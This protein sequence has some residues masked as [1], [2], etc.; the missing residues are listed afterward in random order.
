MVDKQESQQRGRQ[1]GL[2][3]PRK[4]VQSVHTHGRAQVPQT[5][6]PTTRIPSTAFGAFMSPLRRLAPAPGPQPKPEPA[7]MP[8]VLPY[9]LPSMRIPP[10]RRMAPQRGTTG[11]PAR[12]EPLL[13]PPP[14]G[15]QRVRTSN[16]REQTFVTNQC[17][18]LPLYLGR[19]RTE[20]DKMLERYAPRPRDITFLPPLSTSSAASSLKFPEKKLLC[21]IPPPTH[22]KNDASVQQRGLD[23]SSS[24]STADASPNMLRSPTTPTF[25]PPL[26]LPYPSTAPVTPEENG[27]QIADIKNQPPVYQLLSNAPFSPEHSALAD[28]T[29]IVLPRLHP[30]KPQTGSIPEDPFKHSTQASKP[31]TL[32]PDTPLQQSGNLLSIV[33]LG[34]RHPQLPYPAHVASSGGRLSGHHVSSGRHKSRLPRTNSQVKAVS[35]AYHPKTLPPYRPKTPP[36]GWFLSQNQVNATCRSA[37]LPEIPV[38]G[39]KTFAE[40]SLEEK[41]FKPGPIK[42]D[43]ELLPVVIAPKAINMNSVKPYRP[44][45]MKNGLEPIANGL[46]PSQID[47][48]QQSMKKLASKP[49]V[50]QSKKLDPLALSLDLPQLPIRDSIAPAKFSDYTQVPNPQYTK[51]SRGRGP[52]ILME[53]ERPGPFGIDEAKIFALKLLVALLPVKKN[54][55]PTPREIQ[56]FVDACS[57]VGQWLLS[58][59]VNVSPQCT[60]ITYGIFLFRAAM[61]L[62]NNW[63]TVSELPR[64]L[65]DNWGMPCA[66]IEGQELSYEW[67]LKVQDIFFRSLIE[68]YNNCLRESFVVLGDTAYPMN[69]IVPRHIADKSGVVDATDHKMGED[70]AVNGMNPKDAV[71]AAYIL[72]VMAAGSHRSTQRDNIKLTVSQDMMETD[73]DR[74]IKDALMGDCP[75]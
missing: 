24:S 25:G 22:P 15:R 63:F 4:Q 73:D 56:L 38:I 55:N 8:E 48:S 54:C 61:W 29:N 32:L 72:Q 19:P 52:R 18:L 74:S 44:L 5:P 39:N 41:P 2:H 37:S 62:E 7:P 9:I 28:S 20:Q 42:L 3:S 6:P 27:S 30:A 67:Y 12:E 68:A 14:P 69:T 17:K 51:F 11:R 50:P 60:G 10:V 70:N 75:E 21:D 26:K 46:W 57:I 40:R 45:A 49:S 65:N 43:F 36:A 53:K 16:E 34:K 58:Y 66:N 33:T 13:R 71:E 47:K 35:G 64:F 59:P 1:L 23:C 31:R